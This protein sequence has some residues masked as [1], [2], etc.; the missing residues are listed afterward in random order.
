MDCKSQE[1]Q[2]PIYDGGSDHKTRIE[3]AADDASKRVPA[4][5]VEP[6]PELVKSLLGQEQSGPVIEVGIKFVD[7]GLISEHTEEAGDEG[8]NV[9]EGEDADADKELLLLG[10]ELERSDGEV[11]G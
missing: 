7:H 3:S 5:T 10:L 9:D 6:V 8:E 2:S 11:L 4:L 1:S